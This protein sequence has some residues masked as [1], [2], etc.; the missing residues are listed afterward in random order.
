M[1]DWLCYIICQVSIICILTTRLH[2]N[3]SPGN[4]IFSRNQKNWHRLS[5]LEFVREPL[6]VGDIGWL[7]FSPLAFRQGNMDGFDVIANDVARAVP[8]GS[9]VCELY[10]GVG[11]LGLASLVYHHNLEDS[12]NLKWVRCSDENPHNTRCFSRSIASM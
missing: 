5:G 9:T 4:N 6:P 7:Y 10:A 2:F 8:G 3:S 12:E 11:L 1:N